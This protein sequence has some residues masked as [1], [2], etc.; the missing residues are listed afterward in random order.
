MEFLRLLIDYWLIQGRQRG[1]PISAQFLLFSCNFEGGDSLY[2]ISWHPVFGVS[3]T[4][5]EILDPPLQTYKN[6]KRCNLVAMKCCLTRQWILG[7]LIISC[8]QILIPKIHSSR[9]RVDDQC[10][11]RKT[12]STYRLNRILCTRVSSTH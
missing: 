1:P 5:W 12:R 11:G 2:I 10:Q 4:F 7:Q 9:S 3:A 8:H 6:V